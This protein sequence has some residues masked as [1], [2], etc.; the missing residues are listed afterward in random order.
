MYYKPDRNKTD[1]VPDFFVQQ[2]KD[3]LVFPHEVSQMTHEER[4]EVLGP[5]EADLM[6]GL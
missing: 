4:V 5:E 6:L 2:T 3:W 1:V